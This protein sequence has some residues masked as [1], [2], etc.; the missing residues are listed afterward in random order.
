M[1]TGTCQRT[2]STWEPPQG[3]PQLLDTGKGLL[4]P[5]ETEAQ[6]GWAN[7]KIAHP[8]SL[9]GTG[10]GTQGAQDLCPALSLCRARGHR[11]LTCLGTFGH[12]GAPTPVSAHAP[13]WAWPPTHRH[14]HVLPHT[15]QTPPAVTS[16]RP[17]TSMG[18]FPHPVPKLPPTPKSIPCTVPSGPPPHAQS[19]S[20]PHASHAG[21]MLC[22]RALPREL[23]YGGLHVRVVSPLAQTPRTPQLSMM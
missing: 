21:N 8:R 12:T 17:A 19:L 20:K 7:A 18:Y 14:T 15:S 1:G 23:S 9:K 16:H 6:V 10:M 11:A 13:C 4:F 5:G 22:Q 2:H 3:T